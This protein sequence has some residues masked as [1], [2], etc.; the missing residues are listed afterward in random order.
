MKNGLPIQHSKVGERDKPRVCC[1]VVK[2]ERSNFWG[3]RTS[4]EGLDLGRSQTTRTTRRMVCHLD[5][6]LSVWSFSNALRSSAPICVV[7]NTASWLCDGF[8]T[9]EGPNTR[10]D[11]SSDQDSTIGHHQQVHSVRQYGCHAT[12]PCD[13]RTHLHFRYYE[14]FTSKWEIVSCFAFPN[15]GDLLTCQVR[16]LFNTDPRFFGLCV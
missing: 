10:A 6:I 9:L 14:Y 15:F 13:S 1:S 3:Q 12:M 7:K 8:V 4:C 2:Y 16:H 5:V 11:I